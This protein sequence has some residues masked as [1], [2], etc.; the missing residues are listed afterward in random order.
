L[1]DEK[2]ELYKR[3]LEMQHT[4]T[5]QTDD[6]EGLFDFLYKPVV[7]TVEIMYHDSVGDLLGV[8][9]VDVSTDA[10][11]SVYHYFDPAQGRRSLGVFSAVFEIGLAKQWGRPHYYLGYWIDGCKTMQYKANYQPHEMLIDGIWQRC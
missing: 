8:S 1:T 9:I 10:L 5:S 6:A 11:S 3:Y 2:V 4:G 7:S